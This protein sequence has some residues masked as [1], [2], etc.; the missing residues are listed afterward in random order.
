MRAQG[1]RVYR[2]TTVV[3]RAGHRPVPS[4]DQMHG[5]KSASRVNQACETWPSVWPQSVFFALE[6]NAQDSLGHLMPC[7]Y[8]AILK[9]FFYVD[10]S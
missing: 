4:I 8:N 6:Q 7:V 3:V 10:E 1:M 9:E 5:F 2:A